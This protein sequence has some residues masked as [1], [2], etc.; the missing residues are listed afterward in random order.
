MTEEKWKEIENKLLTF[1]L[2]VSLMID[3]Y[4]IK[5]GQVVHNERI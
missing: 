2:P 4:E 5:L 1:N 3:G